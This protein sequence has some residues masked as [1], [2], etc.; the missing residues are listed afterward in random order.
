M[1]GIPLISHRLFV[2][3][4][5]PA[6]GRTG[7]NGTVE[8]PV[9]VEPRLVST[10]RSGRATHNAKHHG[11]ATLYRPVLAAGNGAVEA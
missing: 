10:R 11:L 6:A 8:A 1:N 5:E 7:E 9:D 2:A 4:L 3:A